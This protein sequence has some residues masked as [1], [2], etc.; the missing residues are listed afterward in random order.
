LADLGG[1]V[2]DTQRRQLFHRPLYR[3]WTIWVGS[4]AVLVG[5]SHNAGTGDV[6]DMLNLLF[7]VAFQ[8]ALFALLPASIRRAVRDRKEDRRTEVRESPTGGDPR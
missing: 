6:A 8:W 3:D 1:D 2:K 7:V 4:I 5:L